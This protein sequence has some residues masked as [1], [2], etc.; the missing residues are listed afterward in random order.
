[1][2]KSIV[3][4]A[5]PTNLLGVSNYIIH[6]PNG[7]VATVRAHVSTDNTIASIEGFDAA[8]LS[9]R[10]NVTGG[11]I[12]SSSG[13]GVITLEGPT[14]PI[15]QNQIAY[16]ASGNTLYV[17]DPATL[18][19]WVNQHVSGANAVTFTANIPILKAAGSSVVYVQSQ[20]FYDGLEIGS[21]TGSFTPGVKIH[22]PTCRPGLTCQ[23]V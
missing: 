4:V 6:N 21:A 10:V 13:V 20:F 19:A 2:V 17:S 15:A 12:A 3:A 16:T 23:P 1:M 7:I 5:N 22:Q 9:V 8:D 14:G 18:N 11:T